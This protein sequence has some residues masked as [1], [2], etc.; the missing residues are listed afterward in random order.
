MFSRVIEHMLNFMHMPKS[1][2]IHL[3]V[4][5]SLKWVLDESLSAC[6]TKLCSRRV[7]FFKI[8]RSHHSFFFSCVHLPLNLS[9]KFALYAMSSQIYGYWTELWFRPFPNFYSSLYT[10]LLHPEVPKYHNQREFFWYF[11]LEQ[12]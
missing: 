4:C 2:L 6:A 11:Q 10:D 12:K 3:Y 7:M 9:T 5:A 1:F 8:L